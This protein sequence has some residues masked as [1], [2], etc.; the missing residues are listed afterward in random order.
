MMLA[1]LVTFTYSIAQRGAIH[2]DMRA[3]TSFVSSVY[4][5]PRGWSHGGHIAFRQVPTGG[6]FTVWL[7]SADEMRSFSEDCSPKWDCR[8]GRDVIINQ[9]RWLEGS[10]LWHGPLADYRTMI[11][12][13][14]TGHWLGLGHEP[15]PAPSARAPVMMQQSK[16]TGACV[17]NPW[18][19]AQEQDKVAQILAGAPH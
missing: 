8:V 5:D 14:E 11:L 3:F 12:N 9:T 1:L 2:A 16:G 10:P 7:A 18:P 15:C 13:H 6:N 4:A 17:P 19:L